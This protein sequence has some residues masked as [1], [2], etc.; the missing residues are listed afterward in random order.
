MRNN[1]HP[2]YEEWLHLFG[3][4]RV[5][6][7]LAEGP[8]DTVAAMDRE[9]ATDELG[10]E[11]PTV[12]FGATNMDFSMLGVGTHTNV[13]NSLGGQSFPTPS[14][15]NVTGKKRGRVAN[16]LTKGLSEMAEAF[17]G[18]F[19]DSNETMRELSRRIRYAQ[20]LSLQRRQVNAELMDH[21]LDWNQRLRAATMI[22]QEPQRV[23][24]FFSLPKED[25]VGW[26]VL[27]LAGVLG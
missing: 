16:G 3:V 8:A 14:S 9:A 7:D 2:Y 21:P 6:R 17:W 13:G 5:I 12:H 20:D 19:A 23:D 27:L 26:V 4:D 10:D 25:Q 24:F 15:S 18:F 22:V 1:P 11:S